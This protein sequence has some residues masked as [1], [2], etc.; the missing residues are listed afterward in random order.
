MK[1]DK[2]ITKLYEAVTFLFNKF[3]KK[4]IVS[5]IATDHGYLAEKLS[6]DKFIEKVIATDI[7]EKSLNK[8][9]K[10]IKLNNLKNI[11]TYVG[12]GLEPINAT[13]IAV[14]AGVGGFEIIKMISKQNKT[15]NYEN[16]CRYFVL[17]PAQNVVELRNYIFSNKIC[18][19]KDYVIEDAERFYPI[20]IIDVENRQRNK[21]NIYNMYLGRDN[22]LK[23]IDFVKFL[24]DSLEY[25]KFIEK[26]PKKRIW[27]DRE[28]RKKYKLKLLIEKLI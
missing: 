6:K 5:D 12:D 27:F 4:V 10:L 2:R 15:T 13:D 8:L 25:L 3:D 11:E 24:K 26:I 14:I 19:L 23:D 21:K 18:L 20:L 17:Q 7:S 22:N 1:T 28:L 16:K 9:Q